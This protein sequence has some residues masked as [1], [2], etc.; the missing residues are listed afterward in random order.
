MT[1]CLNEQKN[2]KGDEVVTKW[3]EKADDTNMLV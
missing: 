2:E 3:N 1:K